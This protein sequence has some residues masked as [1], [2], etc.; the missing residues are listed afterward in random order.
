MLLRAGLEIA[1]R[2][3]GALPAP[4]AYALADLAGD[5]WHRF[6]PARRR[7][8]AANLA[9]VC[10]ATGRP[11]SGRAFASLVRTAFRNHARYYLELLRAPH[12]PAARIAEIVDVP[13]WET[14]AAALTGRPAML[15]SWH[16]GNFE[17]FGV[18][19]AT[20]GMRPLAPIEEIEPRE[21]FEFLA[22]RRGSGA[23]E[24]VPLRNARTAL[25]RRLREGGLVAIIGD[26][27]LEGGGQ[28]VTLFGHPVSIPT[29]PATL[30]V[31]HGAGVVAGRA[32]R[33]GP[34][35]FVVDGEV[36]DVPSSGH[37][38]DDITALTTRLAERLE[39]DIAAAPEQW[40]GAFQPVWPDLRPQDR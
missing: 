32:L 6:A 29:G 18:Y 33:T 23:V 2:L 35:R 9:R 17:P 40:W 37:R 39:R 22:V 15:V 38:R 20:K 14:Y 19:L 1:D 31:T 36:I 3:A 34:D 5:A 28:E 4:I 12:Y 8:V 26:R 13:G 30:A 27:L 16:L 11:S 7:L 25:T 10:A 24:L 21:L